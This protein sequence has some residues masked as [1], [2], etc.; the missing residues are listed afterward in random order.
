MVFGIV[1]LVMII[2]L[3]WTIKQKVAFIHEVVEKQ[4]LRFTE[5]S[6]DVALELGSKVASAA[7]RKVKNA[8]VKKTSKDEK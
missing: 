7:V 1:I 3:L 4:I 2:V 6:A 8:V 5:N